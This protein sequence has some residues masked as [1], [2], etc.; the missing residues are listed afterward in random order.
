MKST[1]QALLP[2]TS[3]LLNLMEKFVSM[4]QKPICSFKTRS[5]FCFVLDDVAPI[6]LSSEPLE[7]GDVVTVSGFG[8]T[9]DGND[10]QRKCFLML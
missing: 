5:L 7:A 3:D 1:T 9:S 10:R 6:A 2:T 8:I 4:A